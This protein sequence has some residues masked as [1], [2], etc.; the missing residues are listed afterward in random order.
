[1]GRESTTCTIRAIDPGFDDLVLSRR[2]EAAMTR[3]RIAVLLVALLAPLLATAG[4]INQDLIEAARTGDAAAVEALLAKGADVNAKDDRTGGT[5]LMF[6]ALE[7]HTDVVRLLVAAGAD[8]NAEYEEGTTPSMLAARMGH[9]AVVQ[10]LE[11]AG[12]RNDESPVPLQAYA[13]LIKAAKE[14]D[15]PAVEALLAQGANPNWNVHGWTALMHASRGGH[16]AVV[17]ALLAGGADVNAKDMYGWTALMQAAFRGDTAAVRA[18]LA[19]GA[20]VHAKDREGR[21]ALSFAQRKGH[22]DVV[23]LLK[24]AGA[25]E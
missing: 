4:D 15:A 24:K 13:E 5:A 21:T 1:M 20:D 12:A 14:G 23:Q 3:T 8:V 22:T 6:A 10:L 11:E 19:A 17:E 9:P 7:G 18:L 2:E 16:T 25:K